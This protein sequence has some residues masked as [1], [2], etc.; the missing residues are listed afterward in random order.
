MIRPRAS[1]I[2]SSYN[3][4]RFLP[5]A[6]ESAVWIAL[7][8]SSEKSIGTSTRSRLFRSMSVDRLR[9][10]HGTTNPSAAQVRDRRRPHG[11]RRGPTAT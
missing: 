11:Q 9:R 8:Q 1:I 6:I 7:K 3:Y 10:D 4:A 2:I 5:A